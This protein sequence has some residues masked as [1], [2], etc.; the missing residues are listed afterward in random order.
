MAAVSHGAEIAVPGSGRPMLRDGGR[1]ARA[2][3]ALDRGIGFAVELITSVLVVA[4]VIIL[5][6]GVFARYVLDSPLVWSD[7]LASLLF[8]WLASLG[9]VVAFRREQHM[10]MTGLLS[11]AA[12]PLRETLNLVALVCSCVF[13]L[14]LAAPAYDYAVG[15]API[16]TPALQLSGADR[17]ISLPIAIA[18]ML[19]FTLLRVMRL[20]FR[21]MLIA[22]AAIV[23]GGGVLLAAGPVLVFLGNLNLILFFVIVVAVSVLAS[24]PIGFAFGLASFAYLSLSTH[25]PLLIVVNR[26]DEGMSNSVLL[27][28]PLFVLLGGV[29]EMNGMARAMVVFLSNLLG[30]VRGGLS[31]VLLGAIYLV[32][33]I[34]GS[35]AA[36]M[37]MVAPV[38]FPEMKARGQRPG[39]M[40]ALL[41]MACA[42][43]ETI[44]PS[45]VLIVVGTVTSVSISAL[46]TGGLLPGV[47]LAL[48]LAAVARW[49]HRDEDLSHVPR[50]TKRQILLSFLVALPAL[51]LPVVIRYA[52]VDG[53]TTATE[54]STI[55]IVYGIV[56][57]LIFYREFDWRRVWPVLV[58]TGSLSGAILFIIGTASAMAWS[59]TQSGFAHQLATAMMSLPGGKAG[60]LA[61]S[62]VLFIVLGSVLEG[63]PV[64]VLFGPLLFPIA[65]ELG[66]NEVHYAIV[67]VL[68]MGIGLFAPPFG[69][70]Y[71]TACII[72]RVEP[73]EGMRPIVGYMI[74][75]IVGLLV[76]A[77]VPW[78]SIGFL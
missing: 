29:I 52:V 42:M 31:F 21:S 16:T 64:V 68:A 30:H 33:G 7:E 32:S 5:F 69:V 53:V 74:A 76:I 40:I 73:H 59:L 70:G 37:A 27:A 20:Q 66:I 63:I 39:D 28:V 18:L 51:I 43:S 47:V 62:I 14:L 36:D 48:A 35:K 77:F 12:P 72:G 41:S 3:A 44:P 17:A 1:P 38:L 78:F 13:L 65:Q 26:M 23:V 8:L 25:I 4:E 58:E 54:V 45:L 24:V 49:R 56:I 60:F 15:Q 71:Y 67:A 11:R 10:R 50:A 2:I 34:A 55:G 6:C 22:L 19:F 61:V 75:L 9:T 57:G 46:F